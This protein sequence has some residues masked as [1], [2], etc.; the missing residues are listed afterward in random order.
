MKFYNWIQHFWAEILLL[1]IFI[2]SCYARLYRL[3]PA[4]LAAFAAIFCVA[5]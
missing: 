3:M 2:E 1:K 4:D 5:L